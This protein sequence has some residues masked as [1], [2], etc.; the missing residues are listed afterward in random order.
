MRIVY[1]G[2]INFVYNI[3]QILEPGSTTTRPCIRITASS[4]G[5]NH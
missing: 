5:P 4:S 1:G 3:Y 2:Y